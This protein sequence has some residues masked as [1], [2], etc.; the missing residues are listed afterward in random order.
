MSN[1]LKYRRRMKCHRSIVDPSTVGLFARAFFAQLK[2][3]SVKRA[4]ARRIK[5]WWQ[6]ELGGCHHPFFMGKEMESRGKKKRT[7][8]FLSQE[9]ILFYLWCCNQTKTLRAAL[10]Y[11]GIANQPPFVT[12]GGPELLG[13]MGLVDGIRKPVM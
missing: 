2:G 5:F 10:P 12:T 4:T 11:P 13:C 7:R 8:F 9:N 6:Q 1:N 3:V